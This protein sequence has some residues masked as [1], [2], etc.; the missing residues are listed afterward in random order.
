MRL[1]DRLGCMLED[2]I[3][4]S[5]LVGMIVVAAGQ[6]FLRNFFDVG[7]IWTDELLRIL[8]LWIA[9]AGAVAASR[10]DKQINIAILDRFLPDFLAAFAKIL[11]HLFTAAVCGLVTAVSVQFVLTS[12]EYGDV[13]LGRVPAWLL[14]LALPIGFALLTWRYAVFSVRGVAR[15]GRHISGP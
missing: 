11:I 6:I 15:L 3:L 4:V 9:L 14:Q 1:A 8:V 5:I 12:H 2:V 10:A 13:L 7:F